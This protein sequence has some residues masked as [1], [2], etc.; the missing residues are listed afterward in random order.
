MTTT[1]AFK[2][3]KLPYLARRQVVS[4]MT[5]NE[6]INYS[7]LSRN[8]KCLVQCLNKKCDYFEATIQGQIICLDTNLEDMK[9]LKLVFLPELRL[10]SCPVPT[11][12]LVVKSAISCRG[13]ELEKAEFG[14]R[15][16][17]DHLVDIFHC[18]TLKLI[19]DQGSAYYDLVSIR[20]LFQGFD[21]IGLA[22]Q[23]TNREHALKILR[24]FKSVRQLSIIR[25][26]FERKDMEHMRGVVFQKYDY[27]KLAGSFNVDI[28]TIMNMDCAIL[29]IWR[30]NMSTMDLNAFIRRWMAGNIRNLNL[31]TLTITILR[32]NLPVNYQQQIF[33]EIRHSVVKKDRYKEF[34]MPID[35][36]LWKNVGEIVG[37]YEIEGENERK[38]TIQLDVQGLD[39]R[40]KFV[41]GQ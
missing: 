13:C 6:Q 5:T 24:M 14:T 33:H 21:I 17:I 41:V 27:F 28:G 19:F 38:A 40:F 3:M 35:T 37:Q 10:G 23:D 34:R 25:V 31:Q 12:P 29:E 11:T 22:I 1:P 36:V 39:F 32:A 15:D 4:V 20:D 16:W 2:F 26:Q 30:S 8:S 7:L 9:H 18:K